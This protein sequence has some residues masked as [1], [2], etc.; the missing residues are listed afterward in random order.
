MKRILYSALFAGAALALASCSA[1]EPMNQGV[2]DGNVSFRVSLPDELGSRFA[3]G[4]SIDQI[5]YTVFDASGEIYITSGSQKWP[6]QQLESTVTIKLVPGETYNIVFFADSKA[7]EDAGKTETAPGA[8]SYNV[9]TA[10]FDVDYAKV[11]MN[12][13]IFDAFV[14]RLDAFKVGT[15]DNTVR[16]YRPFAQVNI[17]TDD[18]TCDAVNVYELKNYSSTLTFKPKNMISGINFNS[19]ITVDQ[20]DDVVYTLDSF[21]PL[22]TDPFPYPTNTSEPSP[23]QYIEMNYILVNPTLADKTVVDASYVINGKDNSVVNT[24]PLYNLP[25]RSNYRTNIFGSLL[26]TQQEFNVVIVPAFNEPPFDYT[27][28]SVAPA[29]NDNGEYMLTSPE[30]IN[31]MAEQVQGGNTFAGQTFTLMNDIT[32]NGP[33][34]P[35]GTYSANAADC[36]P[37]SGTINGNQKTLI[38]MQVTDLSGDNATAAPIG[39]AVGATINSLRV[40]RGT[41]T[42]THYAAG[43]VAL[44]HKN[45][46]LNNC[47]IYGT[48]VTSKPYQTADGT[49]DGGNK[50]GGILGY[51]DASIKVISCGASDWS[52]IEGYCE[53]G[54]ICGGLNFNQASGTVFKGNNVSNINIVQNFTNGYLPEGDVKLSYVDYLIGFKGTN[55]NTNPDI[56]TNKINNTHTT[57]YIYGVGTAQELANRLANLT[58][59]CGIELTADI[60]CTG[61]TFNTPREYS[62]R[63]TITFNGNGHKISN[64]TDNNAGNN[65]G[66]LFPST[67]G[68]TITDLIIENANVTAASYSGILI[69]CSYSKTTKVSNV[70]FN[71]C[72]LTSTGKKC[73]IVEGFCA[74]GGANFDNIVINN[75]TVIAPGGQAGMVTG[76]TGFYNFYF[77][78]ITVNG[79][80]VTA[81]MEKNDFN[82]YGS[83]KFLGVWENSPEYDT[84]INFTNCVLNNVYLKSTGDASLQALLDQVGDR[85][86]GGIRYDGDGK[87]TINGVLQPY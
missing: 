58:S 44:A 81:G 40:R 2:S 46:T 43:I 60:D 48:T 33:S 83:G 47:G 27:L 26:T 29:K 12:N 14:K 76:Y 1:D 28:A 6:E 19:N 70:T 35:I 78:N 9:E 36:R 11:E 24:L 52:R 38:N 72:T 32:F 62:G 77:N 75:C 21:Q 61:V 54:G 59:G 10:Q 65:Y 30:N 85:L 13:D 8:Y 57:S 74:E 53:I 22:P 17:G 15:S 56:N 16:L 69:G 68:I 25:I 45:T 39:Y 4:L 87:I 55:W 31:W 41:F 18:A 86:W 51:G 67:N 80:G 7:A 79:G 23:Y 82:T 3:N 64:F 5:Y 34:K 63:E 66:G 50:V 73:G 84:S 20:T 37:F 49:Y 71:N 42:S